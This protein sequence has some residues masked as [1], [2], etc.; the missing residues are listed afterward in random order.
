MLIVTLG[1]GLFPFGNCSIS[2]SLSF[3]SLLLGEVVGNRIH[4]LA[5]LTISFR[6]FKVP[7]PLTTVSTLFALQSKKY[8]LRTSPQTILF[9]KIT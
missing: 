6:A 3:N 5:F 4:N 9:N 7:S 2:L 1:A 8:R